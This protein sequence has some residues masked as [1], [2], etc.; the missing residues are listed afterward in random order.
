MMTWWQKRRPHKRLRSP[1]SGEANVGPLACA[2]NCPSVTSAIF[3]WAKNAP[4]QPRLQG[5]E[6]GSSTWWGQ[7]CHRS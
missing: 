1:E 6:E 4:G 5:W 2:G 7:V 3:S